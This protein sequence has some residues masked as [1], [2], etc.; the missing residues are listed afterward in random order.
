MK[1]KKINYNQ[2]INY[3]SQKL[4]CYA[5]EHRQFTFNTQNFTWYGGNIPFLSLHKIH[6]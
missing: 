2:L 6:P 4:S 5:G 3:P 1:D